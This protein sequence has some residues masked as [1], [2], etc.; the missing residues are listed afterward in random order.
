MERHEGPIS[1]SEEPCLT[2]FWGITSLKR[3][4]KRWTDCALF[5]RDFSLRMGWNWSFLLSPP[6]PDICPCLLLWLH[7]LFLFLS[8]SLLWIQWSSGYFWNMPSVL[9]PQIL[10]GWL[11]LYTQVITPSKR[12]STTTTWNISSHSPSTVMLFQHRFVSKCVLFAWFIIKFNDLL[13][14]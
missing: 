2:E 9:L 7:F 6:C 4:S 12:A 10:Q 8:Y 3:H 14:F 13:E 11:H 1:S 5:W